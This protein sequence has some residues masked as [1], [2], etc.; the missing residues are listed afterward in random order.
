MP[1]PAT[2][3]DQRRSLGKWKW[4]FSSWA[5]CSGLGTTAWKGKKAVV[6]LAFWNCLDPLL[7]PAD[8]PVETSVPSRAASWRE[9]MENSAN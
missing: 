9:K 6:R 2:C 8:D 7:A 3:G 1:R 5:E 4:K